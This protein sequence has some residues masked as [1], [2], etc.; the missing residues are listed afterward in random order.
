MTTL[1]DIQSQIQKLQKQAEDI[2]KKEFESVLADIQEKIR[3]YGIN[4]EDLGFNASKDRRSAVPPKYKKGKMIW[5]GRGRQPK[6]V[7]EHLEAGGKLEDL[8]IKK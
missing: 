7:E 5:T 2:K 6:W 4:A 1:R 8:L 3:M